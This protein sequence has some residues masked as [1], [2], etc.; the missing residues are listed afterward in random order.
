M[1][2]E[3]FSSF[4]SFLDLATFNISGFT[5]LWGLQRKSSGLVQGQWVCTKSGGFPR[6][7]T[8]T[9]CLHQF[10]KKYVHHSQ[11]GINF[12]QR[13]H[14]LSQMYPPPP[15]LSIISLR[16]TSLLNLACKHSDNSWHSLSKQGSSSPTPKLSP[17]E[18]ARGEDGVR[19]VVLSSCYSRPSITVC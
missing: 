11:I 14:I 13:Q 17:N 9:C 6:M 1:Q 4:H 15:A 5:R 18:I 3:T 19:G 8:M 2:E 7:N 16:N 10:P 12:T